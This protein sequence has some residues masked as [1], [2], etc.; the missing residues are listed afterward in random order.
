MAFAV[1]PKAATAG[2]TIARL[3]AAMRRAPATE[4]ARVHAR[5]PGPRTS[6]ESWA[7][8]V[9]NLSPGPGAL[10]LQV[11]HQAQQELVSWPGAPGQ[12][13]MSVSPREAAGPYQKMAAKVMQQVRSGRPLV[14]MMATYASL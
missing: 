1:H 8:T 5:K 14:A 7:D 3:A 2:A 4:V 13:V 10:P 11:L 12:R 6:A 9:H